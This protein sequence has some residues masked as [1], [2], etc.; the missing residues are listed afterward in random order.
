MLIHELRAFLEAHK[1]PLQQWGKGEAKTLNHLLAELNSGEATLVEREGRVLRT[2]ATAAIDV[3]H[4][5]GA[6]TLLLHEEKQVFVDGR[7]R[8]RNLSTSLGEKIKVGE[9]TEAVVRRALAE[10][11]GIA[12]VA[13]VVQKQV[14]LK[15]PLASGSFPGLESLNELRH[16]DVFVS[17]ESFRPEGYVERQADKSTHFVWKE[18]SDTEARAW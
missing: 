12:H 16:Y 1:I 7:S 15:G 6:K 3:Y 13:T 8:Q 2:I 14:V 11:L 4:V 5:D 17:V 9:D 18:L 10:E